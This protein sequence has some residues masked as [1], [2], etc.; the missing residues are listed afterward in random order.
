MSIGVWKADRQVILARLEEGAREKG[1][2]PDVLAVVRFGSM[3][4]G[5]CTPA[6]DA[7]VLIVL[8]RSVVPF[9][10][11]IPRFQPMGMGVGGDVFPYTREEA[12][13]PLSEGW[14]V[15]DGPFFERE[16]TLAGRRA[17]GRSTGRRIWS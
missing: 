12:A 13:R 11:R 6:S 10:D 5:D 7:D 2:E 1:R 9:H 17:A 16:G 15:V 3:A 4:R 14:G 8:D